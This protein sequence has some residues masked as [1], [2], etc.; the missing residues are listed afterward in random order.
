MLNSRYRSFFF[1]DLIMLRG[2]GVKPSQYDAQSAKWFSVTSDYLNS[3]FVE[4][5]VTIVLLN[6]KNFL[7]EDPSINL[8]NLEQ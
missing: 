5:D 7:M 8:D 6:N 1:L 4:P 3:G 2:T